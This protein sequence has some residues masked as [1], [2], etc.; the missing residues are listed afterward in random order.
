MYQKK[1]VVESIHTGLGAGLAQHLASKGADVVIN[2]TSDS[3]TAAAQSLV[4]EI[5]SK[6]DVK[7]MLAQCDIT[8]QEGPQTL[9]EIARTRFEKDGKFQID[10]VI[11]NAGVV[12][13]A[14]M[15]STTYEDFDNT[16]KLNARA[17]LFVVQAALPYLPV[18]RSGRIVNI[19]SITTSMGFWW[20]S[21]YAGTKGAL[22]VMVRIGSTRSHVLI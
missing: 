4:R 19:S 7:A 1:Y 18:D 2:Y 3:S 14:P 21:C 17:P 13:P 20:Q 15:G 6:H 16:F 9:V 8:T 11:N 10:I 22:E 5:E 12:N